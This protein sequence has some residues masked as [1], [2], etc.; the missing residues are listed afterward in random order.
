MFASGS[1]DGYIRVWDIRN[2]TGSIF[3]LNRETN[4]GK[5]LSIDW[6]EKGLVAGGQDGKLDIWKGG[7]TNMA[8]L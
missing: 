3:K 7:N 5:I 2:P 8:K 4:S 1:F 6:N